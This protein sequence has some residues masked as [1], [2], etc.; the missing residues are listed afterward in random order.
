MTASTTSGE[1][2]GVASAGS[3]SSSRWPLTVEGV[4]R[5]AE[6][7]RAR[8]TKAIAAARR[9]EHEVPALDTLFR[10]FFAHDL[11]RSFARHEA[12]EGAFGFVGGASS[13]TVHFSNGAV[14]RIDADL[15]HLD[16]HRATVGYLADVGV[17]LVAQF[18]NGYV[19]EMDAV[20][21]ARQNGNGFH[22][23]LDS[24]REE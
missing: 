8:V 5:Y 19:A 7:E 16:E 22:R 24:A 20:R 3:R 11:P 23:E 1:G 13:W 9:P 6:L 17:R 18:R 21:R 10:D 15:K 14:G 4:R 12:F 2:G